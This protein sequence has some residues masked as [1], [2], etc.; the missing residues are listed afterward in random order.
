[1]SIA[2]IRALLQF[3]VVLLTLLVVVVVAAVALLLLLVVVV[4]L[5]LQPLCRQHPL[6]RIMRATPHNSNL[7]TN[8]QCPT[9]LAT[10]T[11]RLCSSQI[12]LQAM[13]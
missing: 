10:P 5:M 8:S 7:K 9:T 12:N 2:V 6:L 13:I 11:F 3:L 4:V 1:M